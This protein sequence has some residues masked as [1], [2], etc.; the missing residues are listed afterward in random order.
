MRA[1]H[2]HAQDTGEDGLSRVML[3]TRRVEQER[4]QEGG[5]EKTERERRQGWETEEGAGREEEA[6]KKPG[7]QCT[8]GGLASSFAFHFPCLSLS[9]PP[10]VRSQDR[11]TLRAGDSSIT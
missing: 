10:Q 3:E 6:G 7:S 4:D 9:Y 11:G 2:A 5:L 1:R 8:Q